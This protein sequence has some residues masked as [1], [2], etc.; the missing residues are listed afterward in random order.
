MVTRPRDLRRGPRVHVR[1]RAGAPLPG[2]HGVREG[3]GR[4]GPRPDEARSHRDRRSALQSGRRGLGRLR[5]RLQLARRGP[6]AEAAVRVVGERRRH[7]ARLLRAHRA[8]SRAGWSAQLAQSARHPEDAPESARSHPAPADGRAHVAPATSALT[9]ERPRMQ[10]PSIYRDAVV[11]AALPLGGRGS[12]L[13]RGR[14]EGA[15][16]ASRGRRSRAA[17]SDEQR[18]VPERAPRSVSGAGARAAAA[19]ARHRERGL[20]ERRR[21]AAALGRA[22]LSL[23]DDRESLCEGR[24]R[25]RRRRRGAHRLHGLV[26]ADPGRRV[27]GEVHR[28]GRESPLPEAARGGRA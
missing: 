1:S 12:V 11:L 19:S 4:L 2:A 28:H 17:S 7:A 13:G 10:S 6:R 18:R 25:R 8:G 16:R 27:R 24:D 3:A 23:R 26:D 14:Y 20:R 22:H 5:R 21:G 15:G 9:L